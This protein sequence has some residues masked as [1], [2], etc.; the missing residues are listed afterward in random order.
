MLITL[1]IS[2]NASEGERMYRQPPNSLWEW[3]V[4][5]GYLWGPWIALWLLGEHKEFKKAFG[6]G[7]LFAL[8]ATYLDHVG[9]SLFL[10]K[11]PEQPVPLVSGNGVWNILAAAPTAI[12]IN[13]VAL[14][15]PN[16]LW[17]WIIGVVVT[18]A[19][20]EFFALLTT[21]LLSYPKW[22][23]M[24]SIAVYVLMYWLTIWYTRWIWSPP[25]IWR[26]P[27]GL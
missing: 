22:S 19:G 1:Y 16:Q 20:A 7:V 24:L 5:I 13:E 11:Y 3:S 17:Y 4:V 9:L 8:I 26:P 27:N 18:N 23:P 21:D 15:K 25:S 14:A 10:W 12:L 2:H 6:A